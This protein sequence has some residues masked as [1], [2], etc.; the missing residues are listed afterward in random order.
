MLRLWGGNDGNL[1]GIT[2]TPSARESGQAL[3]PLR[4]RRTPRRIYYIYDPSRDLRVTID[5][6]CCT[7][8]IT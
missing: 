7:A 5:C 3:T 4:L 1:Q 2:L 8:Q 6:F